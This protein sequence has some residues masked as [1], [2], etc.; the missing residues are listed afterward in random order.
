MNVVIENKKGIKEFDDP[1]GRYYIRNGIV[2]VSK[3]S[4]ILDNTQI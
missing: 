1:E 3:D 4:V 2:I